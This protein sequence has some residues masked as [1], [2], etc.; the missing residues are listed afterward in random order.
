MTAREELARK[1]I[2]IF[3]ALDFDTQ[4]KQ[5]LQSYR[6]QMKKS[7]KKPQGRTAR[8]ELFFA[9]RDSRRNKSRLN[10]KDILDP[11]RIQ[12]SSKK[13]SSKNKK[14]PRKA[15]EVVY[16]NAYRES[17]VP[18]SYGYVAGGPPRKGGSQK[19]CPKCR[20]MGLHLAK[21]YKERYYSCIYCGFHQ[22]L[23]AETYQY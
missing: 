16:M 9:L 21:G 3:N 4:V 1:I 13:C 2:D 12:S 5:I 6:V 15:C 17:L 7:E 8:E 23:E 10:I 18:V 22:E 11:F 20:S 14:S 19:V